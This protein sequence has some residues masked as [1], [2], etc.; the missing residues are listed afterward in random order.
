[1]DSDCR[2]VGQEDEGDEGEDGVHCLPEDERVDDGREVRGNTSSES[3][4][5]FLSFIQPLILAFAFLSVYPFSASSLQS[6]L[7]SSAFR[8]SGSRVEE[9]LLGRTYGRSDGRMG[10]ETSLSSPF[11]LPSS[12]SLLHPFLSQ[13]LHFKCS[14][15]SPKD[16]T[17]ISFHIF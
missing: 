15:G 2:S 16:S 9:M 3:S 1:M 5:I 12:H 10:G 6:S 8:S 7:A 14:K 17:A 13:S 4:F 11:L